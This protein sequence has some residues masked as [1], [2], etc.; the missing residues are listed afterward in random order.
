MT[1]LSIDLPE[2]QEVLCHGVD[3]SLVVWV[4]FKFEALSGLEGLMD[5]KHVLSHFPYHYDWIASL[6]LLNQTGTHLLALVNLN[7]YDLPSNFGVDDL[8]LFLFIL[9][10][11]YQTE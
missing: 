5:Q 6:T 1:L 9:L 11:C 7:L 3:S 8:P 4:Q 2:L 10:H